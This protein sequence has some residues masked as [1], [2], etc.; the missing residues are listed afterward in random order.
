MLAATVACQR[1]SLASLYGETQA[2]YHGDKPEARQRA[3]AGLSRAQVLHS[4]EWGWKFR[5]LLAS[6]LVNQND[7]KAALKTL[8]AKGEPPSSH[9]AA[10]QASLR[11]FAHVLLGDYAEAEAS[12]QAALGMA[13]RLGDAKLLDQINL[14][15]SALFAMNDEFDQAEV[16]L[17]QVIESARNRGDLSL[18]G[19]AM[20]NL[21]YNDHR[22]LRNE[23]AVEWL[24]QAIAVFAKTGDRLNGAKATGN[25]GWAYL[26]LGAFENALACFEGAAAQAAQ[27]GNSLDQITSLNGAAEILLREHK[28]Q[29]AAERSRR[30][31]ELARKSGDMAWETDS[32]DALAAGAVELGDWENAQRYNDESRALAVKLE[33]KE[34]LVNNR[35]VDARIAAGR[36]QYGKARRLFDEVLASKDFQDPAVRLDAQSG[37][38][39]LYAAQGELQ[40]AETQFRAA[41][42][43]SE[44]WRG[45]LK[46][47]ENKVTYLSSLIELFRDYVSFLMENHQERRAL[48]VA[49]SSRARVLAEKLIAEPRV[50]TAADFQDLA[51]RTR[52]VL[53][54]YWLGPRQSY[55]WVI[56]GDTVSTAVL[57]DQESLGSLVRK[58]QSFLE[59]DLG[60]PISARNADGA[61]LW[62]MLVGPARKLIPAGARIVLVPDGILHSL[63]F[64]TLPVPGNRWHYW[65]E[66]ATV[67]IAPSLSVLLANNAPR[68]EPAASVLLIG[69]PVSPDADFPALPHAA[70]E[71]KRVRRHFPASTARVYEGSLAQPAVYRAASPEKFR[72]IHFA[73]HSLPNRQSPLDSALILSPRQGVY[74]LYARDI[75][76]VPLRA[77]LVT[78]SACKSAGAK[79]YSGEGQVGLAWAFLQAGASNVIAGLWDVDDTYT[80]GL[81]DA[82]YSGLEH[83]LRPAEALR[84]AKLAMI[85]SQTV[86]HKPYYWGSFLIFTGR[87]R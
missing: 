62:Q 35:E 22:D 24:K 3:A 36:K 79:T 14:N 86:G 40:Q 75:A 41:I 38:A 57:P 6:I 15:Y 27:I 44:T 82:L 13:A 21:G 70:D 76:G 48:E 54:A 65:I 83:G 42:A 43:Y 81:M 4:E 29:A 51:R 80:P 77:E 47:D 49:A 25:L 8:D 78:I 23:E 5:I 20:L 69:D 1:Q 7:P 61:E 52:S 74:K 66:D 71:V 87:G 64:E 2:L 34:G 53:L 32:L 39:K 55:L 85:R 10:E 45:R 31:L 67:R 16:K 84:N 26:D 19:R 56:T 60:D 11:G 18:Q 63:N 59:D 30:A 68:H 12:L 72:V 37:L 50:G 46:K 58:Y 9:V 28:Y 33:S 73:A 17:R